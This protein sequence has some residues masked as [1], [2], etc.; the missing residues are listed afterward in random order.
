M[1]SIIHYKRPDNDIGYISPPCCNKE[2]IENQVA[3]VVFIS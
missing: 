3:F 2:A 1:N